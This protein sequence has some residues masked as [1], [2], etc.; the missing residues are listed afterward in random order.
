MSCRF[1]Y[2]LLSVTFPS[3]LPISLLFCWRCDTAA[4]PFPFYL[5]IFISLSLPRFLPYTQ[6]S[7]CFAILP[8]NID[9]SYCSPPSASVPVPTLS[10][11]SCWPCG[12]DDGDVLVY[13]A[14]GRL[15]VS[16]WRRTPASCCHWHSAARRSPCTRRH[17]HHRSAASVSAPSP[18]CGVAPWWVWEAQTC[19]CVR[20]HEPSTSHGNRLV[21][22]RAACP[23][24]AKDPGIASDRPRAYPVKMCMRV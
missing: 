14:S 7:V 3:T 11:H 23:A 9:G 5:L 8:C 10:L 19:L 16:V 17:W 4:F 2:F 13:A 18:S 12:T 20:G 1:S 21:A 6:I 15:C 22:E 24:T